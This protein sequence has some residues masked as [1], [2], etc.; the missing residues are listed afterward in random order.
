MKLTMNRNAARIATT[1][2]AIDAYYDEITE[3]EVDW[4]AIE[5]EEMRLASGA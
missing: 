5:A 4:A 3:P 1:A 2:A